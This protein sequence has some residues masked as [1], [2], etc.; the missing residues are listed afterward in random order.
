MPRE[1][2]PFVHLHVH[3]PFSFLDGGSSIE[4]LLDRAAATGMPALAVTDHDTLSGAV[5]FVRQARARGIKAVVGAEL[6]MEDGRHLTLLACNRSGYANLC[7]ILTDAHLSAPRRSPR[8][9]W[10]T[11]AARREGL[12]ALSGCS[13]RGVAAVPARMGKAEEALQ[14]L[15]QLR[16]IFG[17]N[18]YVEV[19]DLRLPGSRRLAR[20]LVEMARRLGME[21]VATNDVHYAR[22]ADFPV[23]DALTCVRTLTRLESVHPERALN[24]EQYLKAPHEMAELFS[25]VPEALRNSQAIADRCED[26]VVPLG[27]RLFPSYP[28]PPGETPSSLLRRLTYQ[29]AERR[30]GMLTEPIRRRL[31]HELR[32]IEALGV[33]DYFLV[34][35]EI[36]RYARSRGIRTS[37][38]GSAAD[39]AVAYALGL[40]DVDAIAR[41]LLFERFL[42]LERA[43]YPDIDI[44]FDARRR[45]EVA[46]YVYRRFGPEHVASVAT[47]NT[48]QAR[49]ALRDLGKAMGYPPGEL[50]ALARRFPSIPADAVRQAAVRLPELRN[51]G[52]LEPLPGQSGHRYELLFDLAE[53]V[54]GFPR[55]L[56][57]HLGGLILSRDPIARLVPL[58]MAAKGVVVAQFDKDDVEA[59][60]FIKLDLLSLRALGAVED[61]VRQIQEQPGQEGSTFDYERI[62]LDDPETYRM[63]HQ[64]QTVGVFQLESP[65]QRALQS[66]LGASQIEDIVASVA[67]IRPG[68]IKGHMVEPFIARRHGLE[69]IR[70]AHP[71][72]ERILRKTFGVVLYQEQ[73][74]EIATEVAGF[75]PGEAD[76]LR[77]A[78]TRF[79]SQRE[80]EEI[81]RLFV[82]Q[83]VARGVAP[84]VAETIFSY[85]AGYAGYGFC[86]AHAA[87]FATTA[88]KTAY[89]LRHYP[90]EFF[91][92]LLNNQPMGFYPP[93]TLITEARRRG[94]AVVGPDIRTSGVDYEVVRVAGD[95]H[96]LPAPVIRVPLK[97]IRG[98]GEAG[99]RTIV[100]E[101]ERGGP[102]RCLYDFCRRV[103][104]PQDAVEALIE[105]G[106][107]DTLYPNRRALLWDL[108]R[109]LAAARRPPHRAGGELPLPPASTAPASIRD[110]S[111]FQRTALEL[112]AM[113]FSPSMHVLGH[114]RERLRRQGVIT[115]RE[116]GMR[117]KGEEVRVAGLAI[118]PHRPP[119]RSGRTVVFLTLEDEEGLLDVTVFEDV[120]QRWGH[121]IFTRPALIVTGIIE[122]RGQGVSLTAREAHPLP[123][124]PP[125]E[126][127]PAPLPGQAPPRGA[128]TSRTAPAPAR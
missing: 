98:V 75:T 111:P 97:V 94:V 62:P 14:A 91:A 58:Q 41:G 104:L 95:G 44:D 28:V 93:H 21:V 117:P 20:Q 52:L 118:R 11:L 69:P 101:R 54:A 89:L 119:T 1:A 63:L 80:M 68:P 50:D 70:Y 78:M 19:Q 125:D 29:G 87:A 121:H 27:E 103:D 115:T 4:S 105:A 18:A 34:V 90:A 123:L 85:I 37:G 100:A 76:R 8:A 17:E 10:A 15:R 38:R 40:T 116:A 74:I 66:R 60:G 35:W 56:G 53:A 51:S 73:V 102:F 106:A 96:A 114:F 31:D 107:F 126:E 112:H 3:T 77:R 24:A 42:S 84:G 108:P 23:H 61:A 59:M 16:E 99:A 88:Y 128:G 5:R 12:I 47:Y 79:R 72:L 32:I 46:A 120:Y 36:V 6:T 67:L 127:P 83:A 82:Q 113:G 45:D 48:F 64:G 25:D 109:I 49:S 26:H 81:G 9:R 57:T 124:D 39:S 33:A 71:A 55:H 22:K 65:A 43:Q 2:P 92:A 122:R 30:Y 13:R 86:E 7:Q 110:F